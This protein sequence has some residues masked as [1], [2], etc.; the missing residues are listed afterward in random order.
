MSRA[1]VR[2]DDGEP[3]R[4]FALPS[5]DDPSYD[6]AAALAFQLAPRFLRGG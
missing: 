4:F 5:P 2:E 3:P 1:F 6:A